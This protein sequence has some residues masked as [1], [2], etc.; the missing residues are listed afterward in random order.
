MASFSSTVILITFIDT[1]VHYGAGKHV[2]LIVDPAAYAKV[3]YG[4]VSAVPST[5][6]VELIICG[7]NYAKNASLN[8][9]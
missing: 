3:S 9:S 8:R 2:I 4:V 5:F 6:F 1:A 7:L